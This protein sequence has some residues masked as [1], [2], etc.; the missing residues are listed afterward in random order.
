MAMLCKT[1]VAR[2]V[3]AHAWKGNLPLGRSRVHLIDAKE[4]FDAS[5]DACLLICD[6]TMS[7]RQDQICQVYKGISEDAY[8]TTFGYRNN[9]LIANI[10]YYE[11]WKHL[12]DGKTYRWRSGIKHDCS[13]IME[14][15]KER[16]GFSNKLG[17][18]FDLEAVYVYPMLK[19]SDIARKETP[20]PL[21]WMLVTQRN[22]GED[23]ATIRYIAPK[24][25][26]YLTS[27]RE[28]FDRRKSSVYRGRPRFSIFGVGEYTFA[29]WKIAVSGLYKK[30][31]FA[32]VGPY[33]GMPVVLDDTCYFIPCQ[34]EE[35]AQYL[36]GLLNS[37]VAEEFLRSFIF[38]DA[39]RPITISVL[40]RLSLMALAR[41]LG[42]EDIMEGFLLSEES[43]ASPHRQLALFE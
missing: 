7:E 16:H 28:F 24:T 30:L 34:S 1:S 42:A 27:H 2:K 25:W 21:R 33:A 17:E 26:S 15:R 11:R 35:E 13:K 36:S 41:E 23:T 37:E 32:V 43:S 31:H 6:T 12:E 4:A 10:E 39:K 14:L 29:P 5:V 9:Q 3:L 18:L 19:S 8:Q 22:V 40:E 20:Q 38:W